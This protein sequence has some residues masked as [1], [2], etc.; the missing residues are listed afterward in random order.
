MIIQLC[1]TWWYTKGWK[2][3]WR[4]MMIDRVAWMAGTFSMKEMART[5]FAPYRQTFTG[6]VQGSLGMKFRGMIDNLISR[7]VGFLVRGVL[8]FV[9]AL[10]CLATWIMGVATVAAWAFIPLTPV[11]GLVLLFKGWTL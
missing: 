2:W 6:G 3:V 1:L 7:V 4:R 8:L 5:L 11:I 9:G 10:G